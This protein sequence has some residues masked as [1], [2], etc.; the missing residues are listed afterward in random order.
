[1][2]SIRSFANSNLFP[3]ARL[4]HPIPIFSFLT[5]R[6]PLV[7]FYFP[8]ASGPGSRD[9]NAFLGALLL[10]SALSPCH[11]SPNTPCTTRPAIH[12]SSFH[13]TT[14]TCPSPFSNLKQTWA[15]RCRWLRSAGIH[16]TPTCC[17]ALAFILLCPA[18]K[19]YPSQPLRETR[20]RPYIE[21]PF[22]PFCLTQA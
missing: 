18:I 14:H 15:S 5:A 11:V 20:F 6:S 13:S 2:P 22:I 17:S 1:M 16:A 3:P 21:D 9:N 10:H 12:H 19:H 7:N 8:P 4:F